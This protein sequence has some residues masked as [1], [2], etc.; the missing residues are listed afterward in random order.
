[1]LA[2][3]TSNAGSLPVANIVNDVVQALQVAWKAL[4]SP[5]L[6]LVCP[7]RQLQQ[8]QTML[9]SPCLVQQ[10]TSLR[11][12]PLTIW[13]RRPQIT[14]LFIQLM[15]WLVVLMLIY[16]TPEVGSFLLLLIC[17]PRH[18]LHWFGRVTVPVLPPLR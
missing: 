1:M 11:M 5:P 16:L 10:I 18:L 2:M 13:N 8:S 17:L 4:F 12:P 14:K 15:V 6:M 3:Q 9:G 7:S